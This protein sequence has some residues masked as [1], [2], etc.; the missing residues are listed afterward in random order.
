MNSSHLGNSTKKFVPA[1]LSQYQDLLSQ[2]TLHVLAE[3]TEAVKILPIPILPATQGTATSHSSPNSPV[4][5]T[6]AF[7][8][9]QSPSKKCKMDM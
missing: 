6:Q 4:K 1:P 5:L 9:F 7:T 8:S 2:Q 3:S